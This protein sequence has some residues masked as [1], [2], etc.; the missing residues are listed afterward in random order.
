M[1]KVTGIDIGTYS[2]KTVTVETRSKGVPE[3]VQVAEELVPKG[4]LA[5]GWEA[6][7]RALKEQGCLDGDVMVAGLQGGAASVRLLSLPFAI[8]DRA[9][10]QQTVPYTLESEISLELDDVVV[11]WQALEE[12]TDAKSKQKSTQ[13][14]AAFAKRTEVSKLLGLLGAVDVDPRY[15]ELDAL[16]M[17]DLWMHSLK[18]VHDLPVGPISMQSPGGTM[19]DTTDGAP[20]SCVALLDIGHR[21]TT[22]S[23]LHN[24]RVV[25]AHTV[26]HGGADATRALA[27]EIGISPD[28]AEQGKRKEA[29]IEVQGAEAQFPEQRLVSD[30]LKK[31]YD[32]IVRRLRQTLQGLVSSSRM[33]VVK[34]VLTG[35]G[36][37]VMNLDRHLA[38]QLNIK[39]VRA[40][41]LGGALRTATSASSVDDDM[42]QMALAL[43]YALSGAQGAR[44]ASRIDFRTGDFAYHGDFDF[45][46]ERAPAVLGW[47]AAIVVAVLAN[48][49]VQYYLLGKQEQAVDAKVLAFCKEVLG[50]DVAATACDQAMRSE[51]AGTGS[52]QLPT[53]GAV[54]ALLEVSRR[55]P[56]STE[57][58]R[59]IT[60]FDATAERVRL[61]GTAGSVGASDALVERLKGARCFASVEK[62]PKT[63]TI[64]PETVE[65]DASITLDCVGAP[66]ETA[67]ATGGAASVPTPTQSTSTSPPVTPP[68]TPAPSGPELSRSTGKPVDAALSE[69]V[70]EGSVQLPRPVD[71]GFSPGSTLSKEQLDDRR[72]RL[73]QLR[74]DRATRKRGDSIPIAAPMLGPPGVTGPL[75]GMPGKLD[76]MRERGKAD[77]ADKGEQKDNGASDE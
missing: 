70:G 50:T 20:V 67:G 13:V 74:E 75:R 52:F 58:K 14:M 71:P 73:K 51:I 12:K 45:M 47:V 34:V 28:E 63:R 33:R 46:R 9:K 62:G 44:S 10:L 4:D 26:L 72:E 24:D 7:L 6:A 55:M 66:T 36:S 27:Q 56:P 38:E 32:P 18:R 59:K 8:S 5:A 16:A 60:E 17:D 29:F 42:P 57:L 49:G 35:G 19:I 1:T 37:R 43:A 40:R 65:W 30:V 11:G 22:L 77:K 2:I 61:K 68:T 3:V 64:N 69:A 41:E 53:Y 15:V 54:D 31:A 21:H 76:L 39:V 25:A 23:V 48:A